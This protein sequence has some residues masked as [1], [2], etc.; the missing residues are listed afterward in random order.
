MSLLILGVLVWDWGCEGSVF[1]QTLTSTICWL[2]NNLTQ[3]SLLLWKRLWVLMMNCPRLLHYLMPQRANT[4]G[5]N[6][7]G[8]KAPSVTSS[9]LPWIP[10][11]VLLPF[12]TGQ[13]LQKNPKTSK[14]K[15][16]KECLLLLT[17]WEQDATGSLFFLSYSFFLSS[18]SWFKG[19]G[20]KRTGYRHYE[21]DNSVQ[22]I[23]SIFV[24]Q[25]STIVQLV[26]NLK[27]R[28]M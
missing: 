15:K 6:L 28:L 11:T 24:E 2:L 4:A 17:V 25:H 14:N 9:V 26:L 1:W 20:N 27:E 10:D 8:T 18:Y 21:R 19:R 3:H 23:L 5:S 22:L 13:T 16:T 12:H 7:S